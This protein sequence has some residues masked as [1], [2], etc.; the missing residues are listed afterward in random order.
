MLA[1]EAR[2]WSARGALLGYKSRPKVAY[3][4]GRG[5]AAWLLRLG[6][7][8]PVFPRS[9]NLPKEPREKIKNEP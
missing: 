4:R 5:Y 6:R 9:V 2:P 3:R 1:L 7:V 8:V